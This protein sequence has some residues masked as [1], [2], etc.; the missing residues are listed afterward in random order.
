MMSQVTSLLTTLHVITDWPISDHMIGTLYRG[1][2]RGSVFHC[3]RR[4]QRAPNRCAVRSQGG[5][6]SRGRVGRL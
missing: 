4:T 1:P 2:V 5:C 3:V 6:T